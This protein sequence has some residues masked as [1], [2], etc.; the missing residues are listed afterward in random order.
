[1]IQQFSSIVRIVVC[2]MLISFMTGCGGDDSTVVNDGFIAGN[3]E[4]I[5][6]VSRI[7]IH[8]PLDMLGLSIDR[9]TAGIRARMSVVAY[10]HA[11]VP[12]DPLS[13]KEA[14]Q[15]IKWKSSDQSIVAMEEAAAGLTFI[16]FKKPGQAV[17]T[18]SL[19]GISDSVTLTVE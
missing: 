15:S 2:L 7:E 10:N 12:L 4:S 19:N 18:A 16:R 1:M 11:D 6:N 14:Y 9:P 8:G 3:D 13:G 5:A 17:I